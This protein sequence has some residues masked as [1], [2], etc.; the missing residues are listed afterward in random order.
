MAEHAS[1]SR[2]VSGNGAADFRLKRALRALQSRA[3]NAADRAELARRATESFVSSP[4]YSRSG[5]R[6]INPV[7][8]AGATALSW[9]KIG[10]AAAALVAVGAAT[11]VS[12]SSRP[13]PKSVASAPPLVTSSAPA[14]AP[15]SAQESTPASPSAPPAVP[16]ASAIPLAKP[17]RNIELRLLKAA[18][19]ALSASPAR[20]LSLTA[21]H[22]ARFPYSSLTQERELLA[23]TALLRLGRTSE[24]QGRAE[25]FQR[26][27]PSSPYAHRMVGALP[28]RPASPPRAR[29]PSRDHGLHKAA[30]D[31]ALP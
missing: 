17:D 20:A 24:A 19:A 4:P 1:P 29:S 31:E 25:R 6:R 7:L 27:Y 21:E 30:L 9:L 12:P 23:V 16:S 15:T 26:R 22:A 8:A 18:Q 10:A 28:S 11:F 2:L 14:A 3:P 13:P 5:Q